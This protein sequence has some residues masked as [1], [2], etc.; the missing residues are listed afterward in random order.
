MYRKKKEDVAADLRARMLGAARLTV[1]VPGLAT[2]RIDVHEHSAT[3]CVTYKK[4]VVVGSAPA[5]FVLPC[6]DKR[7][8]RGGHDITASIM[9]AL[10]ARETSGEGAHI[11]AG[12][13]GTAACR[14]RML[15]YFVAE[16]H[17]AN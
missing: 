12:E 6:G 9:H 3:G 17:T 11:C 4:H 14:R 10:D 16:Y 2:L 13:T 5:L 1:A 7:C 15:F 8:V